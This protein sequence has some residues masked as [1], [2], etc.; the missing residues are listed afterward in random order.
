MPRKQANAWTAK[1]IRDLA[2]VGPDDEA[3]VKAAWKRDARRDAAPLID[4]TK[5]APRATRGAIRAT[6]RRRR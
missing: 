2:K 4:A 6:K 3:Q 1:E 5:Q